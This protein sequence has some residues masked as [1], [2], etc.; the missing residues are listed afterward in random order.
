MSR[1]V[2]L[3]V[4]DVVVRLGGWS[5]AAALKREVRIPVAAVQQVRAG[6]FDED[7]WRL[8]GTGIPFTEIRAGRFRRHGRRQFLSFRHREPV[9]VLECDRALGA[10]YDLVAVE[11]AQAAD[12]AE[13][14]DAARRRTAR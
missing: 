14:I 3:E 8:A 13:L 12:L 1:A 6:R 9:L 4:D 2:T 5:A 7:G 11:T 10:P